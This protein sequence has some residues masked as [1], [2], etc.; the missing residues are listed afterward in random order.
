MNCQAAWQIYGTGRV[1]TIQDHGPICQ[2]STSTSWLL[3]KVLSI[4]RK[5]LGEQ[6][7]KALLNVKVI[8][9]KLKWIVLNQKNKTAHL[10][11]MSPFLG[12]PVNFWSSALGKGFCILWVYGWQSRHSLIST[13]RPIKPQKHRFTQWNPSGW[14][15]LN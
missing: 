2:L 1:I 3:I 12:H 13:I 14:V 5:T 10:F 4:L 6:N 11:Q 15:L 9:N 7:T 8:L